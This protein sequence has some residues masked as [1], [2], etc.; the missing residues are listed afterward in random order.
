MNE[1]TNIIAKV[2]EAKNAVT[3]IEN[4]ESEFVIGSNVNESDIFNVMFGDTD[5]IAKHIGEEIVI[6]GIT[7]TTAKVPVRDKYPDGEI[8]G[9]E[10]K[11]CVSL[12]TDKCILTSISNGIFRAC[13]GLLKFYDFNDVAVKAMITTTNTN[14]G[15]AH[16]LKMLGIIDKRGNE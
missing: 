14:K 13:R 1:K 8:T 12:L 2:N 7:I 11:P 16:T 3:N 15:I 10:I 5:N 4:F 6:H 9:Y